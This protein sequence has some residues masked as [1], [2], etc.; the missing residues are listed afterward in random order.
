LAT[1]PTT[2]GPQPR[3][4]ERPTPASRTAGEQASSDR[5]VVPLLHFGVP[6]TWIHFGISRDQATA[7]H[8]LLPL[9]NVEIP[10]NWVGYGLWS[11]WGGSGQRGGEFPMAG[12][13][14]EDVLLRRGLR[15]PRPSP[16]L[17]AG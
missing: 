1:T 7:D 11:R 13:L 8:Y 6:R 2:S 12:V 3:A 16:P 10:T 5:Y 17:P 14:T 15:P 9:A 4:T